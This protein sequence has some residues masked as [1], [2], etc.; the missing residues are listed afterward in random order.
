MALAKLTITASVSRV[1]MVKM[2]G[3]GQTALSVL[4]L[5]TSPGSEKSSMPTMY[6]LGSSAPTKAPVIARL[7]P[8]LASLVM[9]ALLAREPRALTIAMTEEPAGLRSIWLAKAVEHTTHLGMR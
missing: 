7:A 8:A 9:T 2:N 6:T 5:V 4:V 1:W 3:L